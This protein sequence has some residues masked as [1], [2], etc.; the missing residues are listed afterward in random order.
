[1]TYD[2]IQIP[3]KDVDLAAAAELIYQSIHC[4]ARNHYTQAQLNAWMPEPFSIEKAN[5]VFLGQIWFIACD[6]LG[7]CA[8][9]TLAKQGYIDFVYAHPR[10][11]RKGAASMCFDALEKFAREQGLKELSS[12]VSHVARPLFEKRGFKTI[13]HQFP[14]RNGVTLEN[15]TVKKDLS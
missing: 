5:T 9:M 7:Y 6:Q 4:I 14:V 11:A 12:D 2:I 10:T 8:L 1:M 15:F 13:S 3:T